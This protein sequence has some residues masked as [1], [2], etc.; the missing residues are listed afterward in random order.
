MQFT[1]NGLE[2]GDYSSGNW[3]TNTFRTRVDAN[4][5]SI[6]RRNSDNT[7]TVVATYGTSYIYLG[8]NSTSSIIDFCNGKTQITYGAMGDFGGKYTGNLSRM[9]SA[10]SLALEAPGSLGLF[11]KGSGYNCYIKIGP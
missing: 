7:D 3:S 2:I 4:A 10:G 1:S 5:F 6:I 8:K 11:T 9:V